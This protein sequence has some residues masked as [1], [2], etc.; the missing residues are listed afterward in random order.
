MLPGFPQ[1]SDLSA[2]GARSRTHEE[3]VM[4]KRDTVSDGKLVLNIE[5]AA[6]GGYTS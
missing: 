5:E 1:P 3:L 4:R 2:A 6:E